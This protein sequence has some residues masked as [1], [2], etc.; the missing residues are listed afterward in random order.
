MNMKFEEIDEKL[1]EA[2]GVVGLMIKDDKLAKE[3]AYIAY[4][5]L[6]ALQHRG[7]ESAG[8]IC[9]EKNNE[10]RLIKDM[11]L[12]GQIFDDRRL[13][14][15]NGHLALG[16]VRYSTTGASEIC[17]AQPITLSNYHFK[18]L[19]L[20]HNGNLVNTEELRQELKNENINCATTSDSEVLAHLINCKIISLD[21]SEI[22]ASLKDSLSKAKGAFSLS[23]CLG[24][25]YLIGV[26]DP[27]AFRPLCLG[28]LE[29][30]KGNLT[31]LVLASETCALDIMN[32][33]FIRE[34]EPGEIILIDQDLNIES[35]FLPKVKQK[36]CL[37]E[38][39]YFARPDSQINNV[40]I[41]SFRES[42]G[43]ALA[44]T[45]NIPKGADIVIG[46]PDSGIPAAIGYAA[47]SGILYANGLIKNRYIGRTFIQPTQSMRQLGIKLKLNA[48]SSVVAGKS[49]IL[50]DD[51]I[52]RG[53]TPRQLIKLLK[54]AGAKEV[55]MRISSPPIVWGCYYGIAMK[56]HEL[57]AR[58][59]S[60]DIELIRKDLEADSLE[61]LDLDII[62]ELTKQDK[63]KF[64]TAC[65][66]GDYPIL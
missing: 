3:T 61:Y 37:F 58:R 17:N 22:L 64:C 62:L 29:D 19:A 33:R 48:L 26:K 2:C 21:K 40:Q 16:H 65:F 28:A 50:V 8:L 63:Q 20:A 6:N 53:N 15:L 56:D 66:N 35:T 32:A 41:H 43:Q 60:S 14:L 39:I 5:A 13:N 49:V 12:V 7:Q 23:I 46:V 54:L 38:I 10:A 11:G 1:K 57:L 9:F 31:G 55:H 52:V 51:S 30:E 25:Q 36:S 42:L 18:S 34:L 44:K 4:L 24:G 47:E 27:Q 59:L 45:K